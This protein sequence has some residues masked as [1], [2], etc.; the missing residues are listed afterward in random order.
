MSVTLINHFREAAGLSQEE[1]G[2]LVGVTRQ[3]IASWERG[4]RAPSVAQIVLVGQALEVSL[5]DLLDLTTSN[6]TLLFR[7]D[8]PHALSTQLR[9]LLC[10]RA[11]DFAE[12]ERLVGD[13]PTLPQSRPFEDFD[14]DF[15]EEVAR[16]V[17]D[18]LGVDQGPLGDVFSGLEDRGLKII[19][20]PLNERVSGFSAF[21]EDWGG[22]IFV[23][24]THPGERQY[25]TVLHELAH[26]VLHRRDYRQDAKPSASRDPR[27]KAANYLAA[28]VLLP[29]LGLR[30]ELRFYRGR[31]IPAP[32][33]L[34][35]KRK[36]SAS[37][38]T[39]LLRAHQLDL[40]TRQQM[41]QQIGVL[42]RDYGK[43]SEP[44]Q[45]PRPQSTGR[46]DRFERL[47]Y[48]AL[49]DQKLTP[50]R[51]AEILDR[52]ASQVRQEL[53]NWISGSHVDTRS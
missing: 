34:D 15:T 12:I 23:N 37:M 10:R 41:G 31:W 19:P 35:L 44:S 53:S 14:P 18:W 36:Y 28:A 48:Q 26:L 38:R 17:R 5:V 22:V 20:H 13:V 25:F 33:L 27:E 24:A 16:D 49:L 8:D 47:V 50:S 11:E 2:R 30:R 46:L 29:N 51:A 45:L 40:I 21:T 9:V 3:T 6:P 42:N 32:L 7:T 1:L 52:P 43:D 39:I 4:E